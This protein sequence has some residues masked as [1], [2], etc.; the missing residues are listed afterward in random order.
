MAQTSVVGTNYIVKTPGVLGGEP[1]IDG[2]RVSVS[3]LI[4]LYLNQDTPVD[5]IVS[6]FPVTPSEVFSALA[7]YYDHQAE[8][9]DILARQQHTEDRM[10]D[11]LRQADR[12]ARAKELAHS[13]KELDR[14]MTVTEVAETY[15]VTAPVIREAASKGWV[16]ARKSGS[17][18]LIKRRDAEERWGTK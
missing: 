13:L 3:M 7:Y 15:G 10:I 17:T 12:E 1:R 4:E 16:A 5:E 18:W 9:D 2:K 14:E 8:I 11:P 6:A